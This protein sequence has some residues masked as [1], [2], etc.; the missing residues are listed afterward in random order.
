MSRNTVIIFGLISYPVY[1]LVY[2]FIYNLGVLIWGYQEYHLLLY[3]F[4]CEANSTLDAIF[5]D[6]TIV[7]LKVL[8][9]IVFIF[10]FSRKAITLFLLSFLVFDSIGIL[11]VLIDT[12]RGWGK[13]FWRAHFFPSSHMYDLSLS[14]GLTIWS[15][16]LLLTV[17]LFLL[18]RKK[19]FP[20]NQKSFW[21]SCIFSLIIGV[22]L[23]QMLLHFIP[24]S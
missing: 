6:F 9:Y 3:G 1:I 24:S 23:V 14:L 20:F 16:P 19:Q 8:I 22:L 15:I 18:I 11:T 2:S 13:Y 21:F 12:A 4:S 17:G 10:L 7:L 5:F